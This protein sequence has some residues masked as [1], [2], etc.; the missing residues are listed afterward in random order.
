MELKVGSLTWPWTTLN[1]AT[2][3]G[4][5][6]KLERFLLDEIGTRK[7]SSAILCSEKA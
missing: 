1:L 4:D 2:T 6:T 7:V 3:M 5:E